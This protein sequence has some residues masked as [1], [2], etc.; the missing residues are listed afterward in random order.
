LQREAC[1]L[2]LKA[3][4]FNIKFVNQN[5]CQ[6][7]EEQQ[8]SVQRNFSLGVESKPYY[9]APP[10]VCHLLVVGMYRQHFFQNTYTHQHT[11]RY[12]RHLS[13]FGDQD[14]VCDENF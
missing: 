6:L 10:H 4:G 11:L 9:Y 13:D 12:Q 1:G 7:T 8:N 2:Q 3:S 5:F 14:K